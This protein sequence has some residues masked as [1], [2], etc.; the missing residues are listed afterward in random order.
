MVNRSLRL[1]VL[2][3]RFLASHESDRPVTLTSPPTSYPYPTSQELQPAC[4]SLHVFSAFF[5]LR[6]KEDQF[7]AVYE[8]HY[9][10]GTAHHRT[11][12]IQRE[13]VSGVMPFPF[14][15]LVNNSF[16]VVEDSTAKN[17]WTIVER[18]NVSDGG[19]IEDRVS[20]TTCVCSW[21]GIRTVH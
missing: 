11:L 15:S 16:L 5:V 17:K 8:L 13:R 21:D 3:L 14:M 10:H 7:L 9:E 2:H 19:G 1:H 4:S 6:P 20:T 18:V 12:V